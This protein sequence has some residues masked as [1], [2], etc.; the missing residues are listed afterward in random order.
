MVRDED[1]TATQHVIAFPSPRTAP[2]TRQHSLDLIPSRTEGGPF[3][4]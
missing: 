3:E 2:I 1:I 4:P